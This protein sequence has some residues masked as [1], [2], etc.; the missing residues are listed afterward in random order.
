MGWNVMDVT[1]T[2]HYGSCRRILKDWIP[3]SSLGCQIL[4]NGCHDC[5]KCWNYTIF[6]RTSIVWIY[7]YRPSKLL[8]LENSM[9]VTKG[10]MKCFQDTTLTG[11]YSVLQLSTSWFLLNKSHFDTQGPVCSS[12]SCCLT[13][14]YIYMSQTHIYIRPFWP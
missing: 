8:Q 11:R 3:D 10:S 12:I 6:P 14:R 9:H 13:Y 1:A 5:V 4:C 2:T 7:C